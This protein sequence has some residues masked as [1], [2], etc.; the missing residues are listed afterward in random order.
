MI[1]IDRADE[2]GCLCVP[3]GDGV[4]VAVFRRG[5]GR[6][7]AGVISQFPANDAWFVGVARNY[8]L[9]I[10]VECLPDLLIGVEFIMG[11]LYT[12]LLNISIH[13]AYVVS[14]QR[15]VHVIDQRI[16]YTNRSY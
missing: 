5:K 6:G 15:Q 4:C 12:K 14:D 8:K 3:P 9:D 13:T 16:V 11:L 10:L 1:A 7:A 2:L